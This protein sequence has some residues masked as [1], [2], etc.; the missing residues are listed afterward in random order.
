MKVSVGTFQNKIFHLLD[1]QE[2]KE[3][4]NIKKIVFTIFNIDKNK[5]I[6]M[7]ML[8]LIYD[9]QKSEGWNLTGSALHSETQQDEK[10]IS[11]LLL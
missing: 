1:F 4:S 9:L 3:T 7:V 8:Y 2:I 10:S 5:D 11:F 6:L